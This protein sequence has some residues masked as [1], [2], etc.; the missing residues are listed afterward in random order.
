MKKEDGR[1]VKFGVNN[2]TVLT[3]VPNSNVDNYH[4]IN[5]K[6]NNGKGYWHQS[7]EKEEENKHFNKVAFVKYSYGKDPKVIDAVVLTFDFEN[8]EFKVGN[9][10][11]KVKEDDNYTFK[12]L[13]RTLKCCGGLE[14]FYKFVIREMHDQLFTSLVYTFKRVGGLM[15][16]EEV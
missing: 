15:E 13:K 12:F 5:Q 10:T 9:K 16:E 11:Y 6:I 2:E 8:Q 7:C 3:F 1:F 14:R 4:L